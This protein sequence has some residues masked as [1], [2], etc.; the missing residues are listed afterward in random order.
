M[1]KGLNLE[2]SKMKQG[3]NQEGSHAYI[4]QIR[5][6]TKM[7][8]HFT[9]GWVNFARI[10]TSE[11]PLVLCLSVVSH[12]VYR[13]VSEALIG[14]V[15]FPVMKTDQNQHFLFGP[16][17]MGPSTGRRIR[18]RIFTQRAKTQRRH[19]GR[20]APTL[21]I[22]FLLFILTHTG[23]SLSLSLCVLMEATAW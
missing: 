20:R 15:I 14:L 4:S 7:V 11:F 3:P 12:I 13:A 1:D 21:S 17:P 8:L 6:W 10:W 19:A 2:I 5:Y 22:F 9:A 16:R 18:R 23:N